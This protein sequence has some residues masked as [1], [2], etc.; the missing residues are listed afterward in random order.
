MV[1]LFFDTETT[2]LVNPKLPHDEQPHPVQLCCELVD[3]NKRTM[4]VISVIV[5]PG[6]PSHP[7]ALEKHGITDEMT[8]QYGLSIKAA[9]GLFLN[10]INRCD[11]L[12]A[13]N[14]DFDIIVT[15][16]MIY[17]SGVNFDL[18]KYRS[19]PRVCTMKSATDVCRLPGKY[20]HKWPKLSEAYEHLVDP[21]GFSGAHDALADVR[22]CKA[23][24][25]ALEQ[26]NLTLLP[27]SR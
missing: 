25:Y 22:A 21:A 7:K 24:L 17:R 23:V 3:E 8:K 6:I 10:F 27:G 20:G 1:T 11:R 12:V 4:N 26:Q 16:A 15:E 14:I 9:T 5:N 2:G 13:H 19:I 18:N